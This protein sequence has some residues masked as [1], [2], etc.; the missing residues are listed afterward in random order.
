MSKKKDESNATKDVTAAVR[1]N[2]TMYA[3][4]KETAHSQGLSL[5][6]IIRQALTKYLE[7]HSRS[8]LEKELE[9]IELRKRVEEATAGSDKSL[10]DTLLELL[11]KSA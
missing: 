11:N 4:L 10:R 1:F 5:S 8:V 3:R 2:A 7:E 6:D 9:D